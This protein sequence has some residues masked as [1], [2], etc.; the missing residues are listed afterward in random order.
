MALNVLAIGRKD[1][2]F[3][4]L[5]RA[6]TLEECQVTGCTSDD[7]ALKKIR[8]HRYDALILAYEMKLE[9]KAIFKQFTR[10]QR[11]GTP[12]IEVNDTMDNIAEALQAALLDK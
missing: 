6:L 11:P 10:E 4:R 9:S 12:V 3:K 1:S 8:D 5:E 2:D 7:E